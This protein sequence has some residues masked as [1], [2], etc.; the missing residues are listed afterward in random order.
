MR[1]LVTGAAG[2]IGAHV[3]D[4][5]IE[6]GYEVIAYDNFKTGFRRHLD[7][8][9]KSG[10]LTIVEG[11][12]LDQ[13]TLEQCMIGVQSVFHLAGNADVRGGIENRA[14]DLEINVTGTCRVLEASVKHGVQ[15]FLF[16]SSA[17]VYGEPDLFP[18]PETYPCVQT[19]VYGASK[20]AAEA[21]IQ[22]YSEYFGLRSL[23]FRFVSWIGERYSHGVIFDFVNRLRQNPN[24]LKILGNGEQEKSYLHV[25]DGI[26][27][28]FQ[29]LDNAKGLKNT[30]N[31][32]HVDRMRVRDLADIICDEMGLSNVEYQFTGGQRGWLG[33]SP[34]VLLD[35]SRMTELGFRPCV[36]IEQG[37]RR[38][39]RYLLNNQW[40]LDSRK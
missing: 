32:G 35:I 18:T 20:L 33:D 36:S 37:I 9:D 24:Q 31:L 17:T 6:R 25:D 2:F 22:A 11:D 1:A 26:D 16:T 19:S 13:S 30:F 23:I 7:Q 40:L 10:R 28:V 21:Y 3:V 34:V 15:N 12:I 8:A 27:G 5:L 14:I 39:V 38:T 29:A 4:R